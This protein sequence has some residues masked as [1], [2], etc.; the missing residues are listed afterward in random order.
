MGL[1]DDRI[2]APM[3]CTEQDKLISSWKASRIS[4][5]LSRRSNP[6]FVVLNSLW[7]CSQGLR[8]WSAYAARTRAALPFSRPIAWSTRSSILY[9]NRTCWS[10]VTPSKYNGQN[11]HVAVYRTS[12]HVRFPAFWS[13][14][15]VFRKDFS[16]GLEVIAKVRT[17]CFVRRFSSVFIWGP[18]DARIE[19]SEWQR[20]LF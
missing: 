2:L 15:W 5:P 16:C 17:C 10:E 9:P 12:L 11:C 4:P 1:P 3:A 18:D 20:A 14:C 6:I 8:Q 13:G 7:Q 19:F